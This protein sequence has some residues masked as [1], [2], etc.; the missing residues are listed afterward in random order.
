MTSQG[1]QSTIFSEHSHIAAC[2]VWVM[3]KILPAN[4]IKLPELLTAAMEIRRL[5][6]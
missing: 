3:E 6:K 1:T 5:A 2:P 4:P